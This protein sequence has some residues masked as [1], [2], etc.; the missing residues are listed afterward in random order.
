MKPRWARGH[1]KSEWFCT[2][3]KKTMEFKGS[4]SDVIDQFDKCP[5]CNAEMY[6]GAYNVLCKD[7]YGEWI[8]MIPDLP[9]NYK[10]KV[11]G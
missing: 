2:G 5:M 4:Y 1:G 6:D 7:M 10:R 3:C 11:A 9:P 8:C